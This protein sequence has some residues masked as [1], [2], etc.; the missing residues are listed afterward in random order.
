MRYKLYLIDGTGHADTEHKYWPDMS[1]GFCMN[2]K[3]Q[4]GERVEYLR[5]PTLL[6]RETWF[7]AETMLSFIRADRAKYPQMRILLGGHSRGG[8]AAI[9]VARKLKEEKVTVHGMVLFDAVRR[10]VQKSAAQYAQQIVNN[11]HGVPMLLAANTA[12]AAIE[13]G[14]DALGL[15]LFGNSPIDVIPSN[16]ERAFHAIRDEKFSHYFHDTAEWKELVTKGPS[17]PHDSRYNL[18][19]IEFDRMHIAMRDACRFS[20]APG[21]IPTG[22][23]FGHTGLEAEPGCHFQFKKYL[24]THGAMGGAPLNPHSYIKNPYYAEQIEVQEVISMLAVQTRTNG[25]LKELG[26]GGD[27]SPV[28]LAYKPMSMPGVKTQ[29]DIKK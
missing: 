9:Y 14:M 25:F 13:F 18:K 17:G 5:G 16:V 12:V 19:R 10:A 3:Q 4:N 8:S 21:G 27:H 2:L 20:L 29:L 28:T 15:K 24:A 26:F 6:G 11:S 1:R 7:I 23:G 22:I